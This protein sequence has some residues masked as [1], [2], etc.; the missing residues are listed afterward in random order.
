MVPIIPIT[1]AAQGSTMSAEPPIETSPTRR[2]LH[3]WRTGYLLVGSCFC[4]IKGLKNRM[5]THAPAEE[6]IVFITTFWG[7]PECNWA[8]I[9]PVLPPLKKS[10][11]IH[12]NRVPY[13]IRGSL[14]GLKGDFIFRSYILIIWL[15]CLSLTTLNSGYSSLIFCILSLAF[16][17]TNSW[18]KLS[19]PTLIGTYPIEFFLIIDGPSSH[20]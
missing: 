17:D 9:P 6:M 10:Q 11:H 18:P 4:W 5:L 14:F 2:A 1:R 15:N 7:W 16:S 13:T 20:P 8:E 3:I 19:L 12:R